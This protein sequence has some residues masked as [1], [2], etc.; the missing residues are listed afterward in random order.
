MATTV[1]DN[2][3]LN[4]A[5]GVEQ[6]LPAGFYDVKFYV[7]DF[8]SSAEI[9]DLKATLENQGVDSKE[10]YIYQGVYKGK[11]YVGVQY[12][13]IAETEG[14]SQLGI[15]IVGLIGAALIPTLIGIG[16]FK[17]GSITKNILEILLVGGGVAIVLVALLRKPIGRVISKKLGG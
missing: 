11:K 6:N 14:I 15:A 2:A 10:I 4:T 8:L 1:I 3:D 9:N 5:T 16:I 17:I 7:T 13:R 12:Q